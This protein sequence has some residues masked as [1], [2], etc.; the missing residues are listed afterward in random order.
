MLT[1]LTQESARLYPFELGEASFS[2]V[3]DKPVISSLSYPE[4]AENYAISAIRKRLYR[5]YV[6]SR[7]FIGLG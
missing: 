1:L 7:S 2:L 4:I 6:D 5:L 3:P